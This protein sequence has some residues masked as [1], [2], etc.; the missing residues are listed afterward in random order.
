M[1]YYKLEDLKSSRIFFDK[2]TPRY[3]TILT[4]TIIGSFILTLISLNF[5]HKNDIVQADGSITYEES[6]VISSYTSGAVSNVYYEDGASVKKG[7]VLLRISNGTEDAETKEYTT[8]LEQYDKELEILKRYETSLKQR[9]NQMKDSGEEQQY[10]GKVS[11]YLELYGQD[12]ATISNYKKQLDLKKP[13]LDKYNKQLAEFKKAPEGNGG[14]I[15]ELE[16]QIR[17]IQIEISDLETNITNGSSNST[18]YYNDL[19]S[20][21]GQ[22]LNEINEAKALIQSKQTSITDKNA[23]L[24]IKA[25]ETGV[26]HYTQDIK[27]G[28]SVQA[29]QTIGNIQKQDSKIIVEAYL[30]AQDRSKVK[31]GDESRITIEGVNTVKYGIIEGR[32]ESISN[33]TQI[34]SLGTQ[35]IPVYK[36]KVSLEERQLKSKD[37][38]IQLLADMPVKANIIYNKDTYFVWILQQLNFAK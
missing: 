32:V 10:Y 20:E 6:T 36:I 14:A 33:G 37:G 23:V 26:V 4:W 19:I 22:R 28:S 12:N 16:A 31:I 35:N 13:E 7:E 34:R 27:V 18:S 15:E 38:I 24:D 5:I 8:Q 25:E 1:R 3:L 21:L 2:T 29:L 17:A 11:R 30:N 9:S